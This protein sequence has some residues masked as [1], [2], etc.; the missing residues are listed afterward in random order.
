MMDKILVVAGPTASGKTALS[1]RLAT[2]FGGEIVSADSMQIYRRMDIGTAKATPSEQSSVPHHMIDIVDPSAN[3]SVARYV[4]EASLCCDDILRRGTL[5]LLVGGTGLYI[6]SLL[7][8]RDFS[9]CT[10]DGELRCTLNS[11]YD[12]LGGPALLEELR[13]FDPDRAA[14]LHASDKKR[15]VRAME[16]YI[17]T[18]ETITE[19]DRRSQALPPRYQSLFLIPSFHDRSIL[20]KR[21]D[22]RVDEMVRLGLFDE[23]QSLLDE[24]VPPDA[25]SM[26]AIGYKEAVSFLSGLSSES[27]AVDRIK[28]SSRRYAKRQITWFNR[29]K[30][31]LR[32]F[33]DDPEGVEAAYDLALRASEAFLQG[34]ISSD[35]Q[36]QQ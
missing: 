9:A 32:L 18:G 26:Q 24:G 21:I 1:L 16:I 4:E 8:G 11:R 33:M 35:S 19:H 25:T 10:E 27:E 28:Q 13:A 15:I 29:R 34:K 23:V 17:L 22:T 7:S 20:Y 5:P 3:Y 36:S 2:A 14:L 30:D 6:D 12:E 31:A